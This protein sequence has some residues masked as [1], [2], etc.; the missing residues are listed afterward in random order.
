MNKQ[1]ENNLPK[2]IN[3]RNFLHTRAKS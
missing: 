2:V 3:S 1:P